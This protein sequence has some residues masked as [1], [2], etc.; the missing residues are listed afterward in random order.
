MLFITLPLEK[1]VHKRLHRDIGRLQDE[2]MEVLYQLDSGFVLHGGTCIWRCFGGG[3]F[4]EDIDLYLPALP[5]GFWQKLAAAVAGR[6]LQMA[7]YKR[8]ENIIFAKVAD[9]QTEVRAEIRFGVKIKAQAT[10]YEKMDG[11]TMIVLAESAGQLIVEKA[12]AYRSRRL[13]RD[14]YDVYFLSGKIGEDA[15]VRKKIGAWLAD[16]P[17]PLDEG[18]L[19][20]IIYSGAVPAFKQMAE[21]LKRRFG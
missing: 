16:L 13:I 14:V 4:S 1:R 18:N 12:D 20:A 15:A 11:S 21:A 8:T 2:L 19:G 5:E 17:D 3:R 10:A 9:G 7:K 6:G